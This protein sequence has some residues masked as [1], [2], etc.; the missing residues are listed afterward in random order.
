MIKK[1]PYYFGW[2]RVE[3]LTPIGQPLCGCCLFRFYNN[4]GLYEVQ[5]LLGFIVIMLIVICTPFICYARPLFYGKRSVNPLELL[6]D[7]RYIYMCLG[8]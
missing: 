5:E 1:P 6:P 8:H 4:T 2:Y 3:L 7:L